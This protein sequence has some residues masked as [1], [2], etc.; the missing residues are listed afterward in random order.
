MRSGVER[1]KNCNTRRLEIRDVTGRN[2]E[3]VLQR[4]R[5][6]GEVK[7]LVANPMRQATPATCDRNINR[8]NPAL[9]CPQHHIQPEPDVFSKSGIQMTLPFDATL[10]FANGEHTEE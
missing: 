8:K 7:P 10:D 3:A 5:G 1:I 4:C 2:R 9:I 6:D